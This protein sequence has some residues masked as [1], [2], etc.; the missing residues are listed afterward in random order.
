MK[1]KYYELEKKRVLITGGGTG[2]GASTV[3]QFDEQCS[4]VD[5]TVINVAE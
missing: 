4:E 1:G 2:M 3:E 5:L